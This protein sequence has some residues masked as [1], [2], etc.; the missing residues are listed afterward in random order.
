MTKKLR[1][2]PIAFKGPTK[3]IA[4]KYKEIKFKNAAE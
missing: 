3:F 2:I 4:I 1:A